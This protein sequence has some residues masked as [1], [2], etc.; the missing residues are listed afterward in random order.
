MD[1]KNESVVN[2][3]STTSMSFSPLSHGTSIQGSISCPNCKSTYL[4]V[5]KRKLAVCP[6][7]TENLS[8]S[9]V[10]PYS[11]T[12]PEYLSSLEVDQNEVLYTFYQWLSDGDFTPE[13]IIFKHRV[14]SLY[15]V[16]IPVW[17]FDA[18]YRGNWNASS[19]YKKEVSNLEHVGTGEHRRLATVTRTEIDWRPAS[20]SFSGG[21]VID[22]CSVVDFPGF[23]EIA[24][25]V[26]GCATS[27]AKLTK[28][29]ESTIKEGRIIALPFCGDHKTVLSDRGMPSIKSSIGMDV[30]ASI[31]GD[32]YRDVNWNLSKISI[33][34]Q[35]I[36]IPIWILRYEYEGVAY[37]VIFDGYDSGR[38]RGN[39]PIDKDLKSVEDV[40]M[41]PARFGCLAIILSFV[42]M[43]VLIVF[44]GEAKPDEWFKRNPVT[45][46]LFNFFVISFFLSLI[47]FPI[48]LILG[49]IRKNSTLKRAEEK[50]K[51]SMSQVLSKMT[52]PNRQRSQFVDDR[53]E[54]E[55]KEEATAK[56]AA[57]VVSSLLSLYVGSFAH[58]H[59]LST[60]NKRIR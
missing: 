2:Q 58:I 21:R 3:A 51:K 7:C 17:R 13:D 52:N 25:F 4:L 10:L 36:Y 23:D 26:S 44:K 32:T 54:T 30:R 42:F 11:G 12:T 56:K 28:F 6:Y 48:L 55:S 34:R 24:S 47:S 37:R 59:G 57:T 27:N 20:G 5:H 45:A 43:F 50:R 19:G 22:C 29:S 35:S 39:R 14:Q 41:K 60:K 9:P 46:S 1:Q 31:P 38:L 53:P 49:N 18:S 33:N 8:G 15:P 40:A 16:L